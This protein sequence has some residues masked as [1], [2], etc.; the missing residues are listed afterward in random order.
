MVHTQHLI[1]WSQEPSH[2]DPNH[3]NCKMTDEAKWFQKGNCVTFYFYWAKEN[4]METMMYV[5]N[6]SFCMCVLLCVRVEKRKEIC[7]GMSQRVWERK[8]YPPTLPHSV[9]LY[10]YWMEAN[11]C[12]LISCRRMTYRHVYVKPV[13][14]IHKSCAFLLCL[15]LKS[16][17]GG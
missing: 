15:L 5:Y 10:F 12:G 16:D 9:R 3:H 1:G 14:V 8:R 11:E 2:V 13:M 6:I 7:M 17:S 4:Y